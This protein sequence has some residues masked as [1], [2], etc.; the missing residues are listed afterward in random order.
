MSSESLKSGND[1][2]IGS[3]RSVKLA[4]KHLESLIVNQ[5]ETPQIPISNE[6]S[7]EHLT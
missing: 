3:D 7:L 5:A 4:L 1:K 6:A 2:S